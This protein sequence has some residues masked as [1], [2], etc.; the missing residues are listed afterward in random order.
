MVE[1]QYDHMLT[2][3]CKKRT[4]TQYKKDSFVVFGEVSLEIVSLKFPFFKRSIT[5]P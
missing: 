1:N 2:N 5:S 3:V 4:C